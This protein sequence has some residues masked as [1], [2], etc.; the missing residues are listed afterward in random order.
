MHSNCA[1]RHMNVL[2]GTDSRVYDAYYTI[3]VLVII[4]NKHVIIC[5]A[6]IIKNAYALIPGIV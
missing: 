1:K 6:F 5:I 2:K 4:T 3:S